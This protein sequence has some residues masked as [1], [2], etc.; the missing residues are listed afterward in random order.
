MTGMR[1]AAFVLVGTAV[2]GELLGSVRGE[3]A[4]CA[5]STRLLVPGH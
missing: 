2:K 4:C 1:T 3:V 5:S